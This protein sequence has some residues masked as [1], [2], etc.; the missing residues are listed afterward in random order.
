MIFSGREEASFGQFWKLCE[1]YERH[2]PDFPFLSLI[3]RA[4]TYFTWLPYYKFSRPWL[5]QSSQNDKCILEK[6]NGQKEGWIHLNWVS[7]NLYILVDI[8]SVEEE[9]TWEQEKYILLPKISLS[10]FLNDHTLTAMV[11]YWRGKMG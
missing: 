10:S 4:I 5:S 3:N 8:S 2:L 9:L 11:I 1:E 7:H 6:M